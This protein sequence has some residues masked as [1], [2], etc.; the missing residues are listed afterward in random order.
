MFRI[1][2][3]F[4]ALFVAICL[5]PTDESLPADGNS[6][7]FVD[8]VPLCGREGEEA[9]E[10]HRKMIENLIV[11]QVMGKKFVFVR[12]YFS[13]NLEIPK[14]TFQRYNE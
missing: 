12:R 1:L 11:K 9:R 8:G 10:K 3:I 6:C 13:C 5:F 14:R 7:F 2:P 4:V